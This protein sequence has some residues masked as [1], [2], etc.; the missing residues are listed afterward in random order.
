MAAVVMTNE[1]G[2]Q[3]WGDALESRLQAVKTG[4]SRDSNPP[5]GPVGVLMPRCGTLNP[6]KQRGFGYTGYQVSPLFSEQSRL[7]AEKT[8]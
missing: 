6:W 1:G 5:A 7:Q 2:R 8:G 4:S 3:S